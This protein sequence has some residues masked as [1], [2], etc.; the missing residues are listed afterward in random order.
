MGF[1][2]ARVVNEC[3]IA[4]I[5]TVRHC[6]YT[7]ISGYS[8]VFERNILSNDEFW[9]ISGLNALFYPSCPCICLVKVKFVKIQE[10]G[11]CGILYFF[12]LNLI[13]LKQTLMDLNT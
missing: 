10:G 4:Y 13:W 1:S 8:H 9:D 2:I 7:S 3:I 6:K 11:G 12:P 5:T